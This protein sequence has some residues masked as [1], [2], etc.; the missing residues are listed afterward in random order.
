MKKILVVACLACFLVGCGSNAT[1]DSSE[2]QSSIQVQEK[3]AGENENMRNT[4]IKTCTVDE[5]TDDK[6]VVVTIDKSVFYE[7]DVKYADG[8]KKDDLVTFTFTNPVEIESNR[9]SVEVKELH[10]EDGKEIRG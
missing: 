5:I 7:L 9:Y 6:L 3:E 4:I 8:L 1:S 10:K 2:L